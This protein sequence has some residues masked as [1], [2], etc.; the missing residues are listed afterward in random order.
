M[1]PFTQI[2]WEAI[3]D[4]PE[5]LET[6]AAIMKRDHKPFLSGEK[7]FQANARMLECRIR[8]EL[9][10]WY[11]WLPATPVG[12]IGGGLAIEALDSVDW[13]SIALLVRE[14]ARLGGRAMQTPPHPGGAA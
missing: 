8:E 2:V 5:L 7:A 10:K 9:G 6:L 13:G 1:N 4:S 12:G 14:K 3:A 11:A